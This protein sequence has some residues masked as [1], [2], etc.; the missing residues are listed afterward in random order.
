MT[1]HEDFDVVEPNAAAMIESLRAVGYDLPHA[2]ADLVDNSLAAGATEIDFIFFWDGELSSI[3]VIDNGAGMS[4]EALIEA[5]RIGTDPTLPRKRDDLGRFGLGLKTA[6]FSQSR[7][8]IVITKTE[9][10]DLKTRCWDLDYVRETGEWRVLHKGSAKSA[11]YSARIGKSGTAVVWENLDRLVSGTAA[12]N[13]DNRDVFND[14]IE[15]VEK[16]LAMVFHRFLAPSRGVTFRINGGSPVKPWDPF[17]S[18]H[19][20]TQHPEPILLALRGETMVVDA[21]ILPHHSKLSPQEYIEA[22]GPYGWVA[23][24]GSI[25][26]VTAVCWLPVTGLDFE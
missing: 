2:I 14:R 26:I 18:S 8:V 23:H 25:S 24:R 11:E 17:L 6:S 16:H 3:G 1:V 22:G 7:R 5:M 9:G 4:E 13:A 10:S 19:P 15:L 20:A 21:Y 12:E